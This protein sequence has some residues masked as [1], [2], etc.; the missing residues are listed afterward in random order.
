MNG[1]KLSV[2]GYLEDLGRRLGV[3]PDAAGILDEVR[4]HLLEG[5]SAYR[6]EGL[7]DADATAEALRDFGEPHDVAKNLRPVVAQL[8]MRQLAWRLLGGTVA[9]ASSG[10]LGFALLSLWLGAIPDHTR[11]DP[12]GLNVGVT[13]A[14]LLGGSTLVMFWVSY[15]QQFWSRP[16]FAR[17]LLLLC[18]GA[19]WLLTAVWLICPAIVA[20][21]LAV[22]FT[23][24]SLPLWSVAA[25]S[26][27]G[28]SVFR[29]TRPLVGTRLLLAGQG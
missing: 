16:R 19:E 14:R 29:L 15:R 4:D 17:R 5:V 13:A 27:G 11:A 28:A 23:L 9:L 25:A 10:V 6:E 7:N 24:P 22:V 20:A 21:R 18:V 1:G 26:V 2:D 3:A 12:I 8:H